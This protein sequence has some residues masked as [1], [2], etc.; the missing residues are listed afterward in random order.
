M[1]SI[2]LLMILS[3]FIAISTKAQTAQ[4]YP[5]IAGY[6]GVLHP[7]LAFSKE[8]NTHNS[9]NFISVGY[10][11]GSISGKQRKSAFR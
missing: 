5:R 11:S 8:G 10:R 7:L 4:N 9:I 1:R 6:V 3:G 2:L